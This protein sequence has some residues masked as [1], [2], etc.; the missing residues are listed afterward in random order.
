VSRG[1]LLVLIRDMVRMVMELEQH[2]IY[3]ANLQKRNISLYS[4]R[5][6]TYSTTSPEHYLQ[7]LSQLRF[8]F[9]NFENA[10]CL[11]NE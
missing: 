5:P 9:V 8:K 7:D 1:L 6:V 3:L 11:A 2:K 4:H 10:L